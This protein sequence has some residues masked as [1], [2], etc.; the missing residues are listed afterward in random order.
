MHHVR[1]EALTECKSRWHVPVRAPPNTSLR[2]Q[3]IA[4]ER[5]D[6]RVEKHGV[7]RGAGGGRS[8]RAVRCKN[9]MGSDISGSGG[10]RRH[11]PQLQLTYHPRS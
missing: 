5:H 9:I 7:H 10:V 4:R 8:L 1:G 11:R 3:R 2:S 6:A